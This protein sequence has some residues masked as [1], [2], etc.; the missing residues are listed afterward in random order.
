MPFP[1]D[2][3]ASRAA[4]FPSARTAGNRSQAPRSNHSA[5]APRGALAELALRADDTSASVFRKE[6]SHD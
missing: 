3:G 2:P 5:P 4:G 1:G 6:V